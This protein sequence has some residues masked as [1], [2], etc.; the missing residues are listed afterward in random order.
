MECLQCRK[1]L[2]FYAAKELHDKAVIAEMMEHIESCY[3]CKKELLQWQEVLNSQIALKE[4]RS[5]TEFKDRIKQHLKKNTVNPQMP[6]GV[7]ALDAIASV[8]KNK[9]GRL[10]VQVSIVLL[11]VIW[12]AAVS[13][14]GINIPALIF[15]LIGFGAMIYLM[16]RKR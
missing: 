8:W 9:T 13:K 1:K 4:L 10:A 2:R 3:I 15:S 12:V 16:A 14:Y 5:K 7:K 11:G 6:A